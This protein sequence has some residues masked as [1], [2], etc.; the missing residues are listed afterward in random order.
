MKNLQK[1]LGAAL[2]ALVFSSPASAG[3]IDTP[4][5]TPP[6][7]PASITTGGEISAGVTEPTDAPGVTGVISTP[8]QAP[9]S[10]VAIALSLVR[11]VWALF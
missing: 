7:P 5:S 10:V 4:A 2:L 8:A 6:P 1:V 11:S 9:D 3:V